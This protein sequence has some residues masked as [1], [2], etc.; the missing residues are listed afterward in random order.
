MAKGLQLKATIGVRKHRLQSRSCTAQLLEECQHV[1]P[2]ELAAHGHLATRI[3]AM[4][5]EKRL[6]N[7]KTELSRSLACL[8]PSNRGTSNS[9]HLFGTHVSVEEPST[10]SQAEVADHLFA[11]TLGH[12]PKL[13]YY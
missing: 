12:Q 1:A 10:A 5:L 6:R 3:G 4:D 11:S 2:L 9:A 8:A 13:D 7:I